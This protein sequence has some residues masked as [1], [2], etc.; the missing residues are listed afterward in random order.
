LEEVAFKSCGHQRGLKV[1][2]RGRGRIGGSWGM[3]LGHAGVRGMSVRV[4]RNG[5]GKEEV[6]IHSKESDIGNTN[7]K[8]KE[9]TSLACGLQ[10]KV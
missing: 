8:K 2:E 7:W 10:K 4:K 9:K 3:V 1:R 5:V 6:P